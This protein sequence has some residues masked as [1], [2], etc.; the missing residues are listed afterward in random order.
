MLDNVQSKTTK[1]IEAETYDDCIRLIRNECG[2]NFNVAS[3]KEKPVSGLR[4]LFGASPKY[5][6][7]YYETTPP[8][9]FTVSP[10]MRNDEEEKQKLLRMT[11]N[12][13]DPRILAI[14]K[15]LEKLENS[16]TDRLDAVLE[17]VSEASL[18]HDDQTL[19]A[20]HAAITKI[21]ELLEANE[22]S[23]ALIRTIAGRLKR[24]LSLEQLNDEDGVRERVAKWLAETIKVLPPPQL[25]N[26][27]TGA[28]ESFD[29]QNSPAGVAQTKVVA[30]VGP[31]G[32]GKTTTITKL[33][34]QARCVNREARI[35]LMTTDRFRI[36]AEDQIQ[37]YA[38]TMGMDYFPAE[39]ADAVRAILRDHPGTYDL[40]LV[41][42]TGCSAFDFEAI[43]KTRQI[44]ELPELHPD[45]Y[46]VVSASKKIGDLKAIFDSYAT[47]KY[48]ALIVTKMDETRALGNIVSAL[49]DQSV[50]IVYISDGQ[51]F[52][53]TLKPATPAV[54]VRP[55]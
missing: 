41:D 15:Q 18:R 42:T 52:K 22:Y 6:V 20:D 13:P 27:A 47:F 2:N 29:A 23:P 28:A 48:R 40:L 45:I 50:P 37:K 1:T 51:H 46:L 4:R 38:T 33:A 16:L 19:R 11:G 36:G 53:D 17:N 35:A 8:V 54:F 24:E 55:L 30:L 12:M 34:L 44:L 10:V 9:R 14:S 26:P 49:A 43:G 7:T 3:K 32:E 21:T 5:E 25:V 39:N 31:T